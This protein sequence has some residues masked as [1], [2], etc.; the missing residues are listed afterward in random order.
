MLFYSI[1]EWQIF[2]LSDKVLNGNFEAAT[3]LAMVIHEDVAFDISLDQPELDTG[4]PDGTIGLWIDPIGKT[5]FSISATTD[6][7]LN[8]HKHTCECVCSLKNIL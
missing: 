4:I 5:Y 8:T 7:S 1:L 2:S 6:K 3:L